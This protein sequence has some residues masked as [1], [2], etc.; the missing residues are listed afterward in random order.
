MKIFGII[1]NQKRVRCFLLVFIEE[2]NART[3]CKIDLRNWAGSQPDYLK[4][5]GLVSNSVELKREGLPNPDISTLKLTKTTI[6]A[7]ELTGRVD[8]QG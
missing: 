2:T 1:I 3:Y 6:K 4:R 7:L 5:V 8:L